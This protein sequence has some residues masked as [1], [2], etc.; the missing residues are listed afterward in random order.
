MSERSATPEG[1]ASPILRVQGLSKHFPLGRGLWGAGGGV[2]R[3]VDGVDLEVAAGETLGLVG[4]S[5][6]GKTTLGRMVLRLIEP[7]AGRIH[8]E[9]RDITSLAPS[10]LRPLRRRMQI[11]FQDPQAALHPRMTV[12]SAV[13][14]PIRV[15]GLSDSEA[16]LEARVGRLLERVGLRR[17][18]RTRYPHELSGGQRQRVVIAR[19]LAVEPRFI[20][21]DEPVSALDVSIQAQIVNLLRDLQDELGLAYLFVAHDLSVVRWMSRRVAVMY[22]GKIVEQAPS[23]A[24]YERPKH[25][26]TRA[27]LSAIPHVEPAR[28]RVRLALTGD[29]PSPLAPPEGCRFH[30]RC[31]DSKPGLCDREVPALRT[32]EEGHSVACHLAD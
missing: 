20:V 29:V 11:V 32:T 5:G 14:E 18:Q 8:F 4:E 24:L 12:E 17:D 22:L 3:A 6:C 2:V 28:R 23:D 27:L 13:G 30:P 15:H 7:S 9:G 10:A 26:Y 25:P 19:A 1:G 31:P 21:A 16:D